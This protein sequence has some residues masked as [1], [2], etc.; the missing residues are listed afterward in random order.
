MYRLYSKPTYDTQTQTDI[1]GRTARSAPPHPLLGFGDSSVCYWVLVNLNSKYQ[2]F[3]ISSG[4]PALLPS[5]S[6]IGCSQPHKHTKWLQYKNPHFL[7]DVI[8]P[9]FLQSCSWTGAEICCGI[10]TLDITVRQSL[11]NVGFY[12]LI[13]S[14]CNLC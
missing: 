4:Q 5:L 1:E 13:L 9:Y 11:A 7:Q 6:S 14:I 3:C 8:V 2:R 12:E 10:L